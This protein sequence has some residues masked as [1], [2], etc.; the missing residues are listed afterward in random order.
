V[1]RKSGVTLASVLNHAVEISTGDGSQTPHADQDAGGLDVTRTRRGWCKP[2]PTCWSA[3]QIHAA[4]G[5]VRWASVPGR[6]LIVSVG[7]AAAWAVLW[8]AF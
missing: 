6:E 3:L 2:L 1:L 7:Q 5:Q 4:A 8:R